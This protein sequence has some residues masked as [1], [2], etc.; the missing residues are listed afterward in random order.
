MEL[1]TVLHEQENVD[2]GVG[3]L[4]WYH[5]QENPKPVIGTNWP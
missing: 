3:E 1:N 4:R 5:H 2:R